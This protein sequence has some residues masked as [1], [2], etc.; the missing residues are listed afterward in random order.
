MEPDRAP[1]SWI[2]R[3]VRVEMRDALPPNPNVS[4]ASAFDI[5]RGTLRQVSELG[6][7]VD[8]SAGTCFYPWSSVRQLWLA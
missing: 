2:G 5:R 3:D 7:V 1:A 8:T 6:V 4:G